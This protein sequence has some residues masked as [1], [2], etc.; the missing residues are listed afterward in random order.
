MHKIL[1]R[2]KMNM[3]IYVLSVSFLFNLIK[4]HSYRQSLNIS[5]NFL[6]GTWFCCLAPPQSSPPGFGSTGGRVC[7]FRGAGCRLVLGDSS[8]SNCATLFSDGLYSCSV[9]HL[10]RSTWTR[11]KVCLSLS[12]QWRLGGTCRISTE[13]WSTII[14]L[15]LSM[16]VGTFHLFRQ[17]YILDNVI[18]ERREE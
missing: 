2:N 3:W 6:L 14:D 16:V 9:V 12:T 10:G 7:S 5:S 18:I 15:T 11:Y 8:M 1:K 4:M 17:F 13:G